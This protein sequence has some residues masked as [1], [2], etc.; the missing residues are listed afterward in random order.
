MI[1]SASFWRFEISASSWSRRISRWTS[2]SGGAIA[3]ASAGPDV[4]SVD[5]PPS[6]DRN[7]PRGAGRFSRAA[8]WSTE[9]RPGRSVSCS[10]MRIALQDGQTAVSAVTAAEHHGQALAEGYR[11]KVNGS[12]MAKS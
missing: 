2:A 10:G 6:H 7:R 4:R 12:T 5:S 8:A 9:V 11:Q 1:E 3:C